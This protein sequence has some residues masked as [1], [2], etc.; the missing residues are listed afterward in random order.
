MSGELD[1]Q[2]TEISEIIEDFIP[3]T[4]QL[5]M[6]NL[7]SKQLLLKQSQL[8]K[9][10]LLKIQKLSMQMKKKNQKIRQKIL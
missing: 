7:L 10:N 3:A 2:Q 4:E 9:Q 6:L 5:R 8:L 1:Q